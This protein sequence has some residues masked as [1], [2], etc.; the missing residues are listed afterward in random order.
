MKIKKAE[1]KLIPRY[2]LEQLFETDRGRKFSGEHIF[3]AYFGDL[4]SAFS[5]QRFN[6]AQISKWL[7]TKHADTIARII[8]HE[9]IYT[10]GKVTDDGMIFIL[11]NQMVI[12]M[13]GM[14]TTIFYCEASEKA[15]RELVKE[16][17]P[18]EWE[19]HDIVAIDAFLQGN[20]D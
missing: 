11:K 6:K 20:F 15:A 4:P 12:F 10:R 16:I 18:L 19:E 5:F 8:K 1:V 9:I 14:N 2:N 17:L 3:L 13:E 7:K